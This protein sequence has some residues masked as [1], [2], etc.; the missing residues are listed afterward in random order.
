MT[1]EIIEVSSEAQAEKQRWEEE[2]LAK[3]LEK[4][5]ERKTSFEGVSLEPVERLYTEA[6]TEGIEVGFPGEYPY[7]RGVR[8]TM[9]RGRLWTMRQYAGFASARD[10][11][12]RFKLLLESGQTG[13]STAFDL[14]TQIGYDSDHPLAAPEIGLVGVPADYVLLLFVKQLFNGVMN[15]V[16]AEIVLLFLGRRGRAAAVQ[17]ATLRQYAYARVGVVALVPTLLISL[18]LAQGAYR[19]EI[20]RAEAAAQQVARGVAATVRRFADERELALGLGTSREH[21][22][23]VAT[24]PDQLRQRSARVAQKAARDEEMLRL[25]IG[26][27]PDSVRKGQRLTGMTATQE[28]FPV[29]PSKY[30]FKRHGNSGAWVSELMPRTAGVVSGR[31]SPRRSRRRSPWRPSWSRPVRGGC[32]TRRS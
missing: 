20:G 8:P 21:V 28:T 30:R 23:R 14:P 18:L 10:T 32:S 27:L 31:R 7:T 2:T 5:P 3:V 26:N 1:P 29:A 15:A 22:L 9:Y 17:P 13:L 24:G 4:T 16:A 6:N 12:R 19:D 11:N 25:G